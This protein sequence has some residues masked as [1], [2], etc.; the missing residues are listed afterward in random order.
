MI[1]FLTFSEEEHR[2]TGPDEMKEP[3]ARKGLDEIIGLV[4]HQVDER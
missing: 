1:G 3:M 2:E 4:L